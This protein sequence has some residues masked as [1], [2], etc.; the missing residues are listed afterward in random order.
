MRL[1]IG[2][3]S[4]NREF[5]GIG[6]DGYVDPAVRRRVG[7]ATAVGVGLVTAGAV[8][9]GVVSAPVAS[10]ALLVAGA[11]GGAVAIYNGYTQASNGNWAGA[12]YSAGTIAGGVAGGSVVGATV[13]DAIN[14]PATR[15]F[16]SM[17]RD[18]A[19]RYRPSLGT[20]GKWLGTG[21]D[22]AAAAGSSGLAG[23]GAATAAQGGCD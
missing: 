4:G 7:A 22:A 20:I 23:A 2:R 19:N 5:D 13:G 12:A 1:P 15:G 8:A 17:G 16:W 9:L 6:H 10:G 18:F 11:V 14:P 3:G 21:P